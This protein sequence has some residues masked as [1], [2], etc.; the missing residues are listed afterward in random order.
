MNKYYREFKKFIKENYLYYTINLS[1]FE[2]NYNYFLEDDIYIDNNIISDADN[3]LKNKINLLGIKSIFDISWNKDFNTNYVWKNKYYKLIKSVSKY[4]KGDIKIPWELSRFHH[5]FTVS[6]AYL[7]TKD[8]KYSLFLINQINNWIDNNRY[9]F[10]VNWK[11]AMDVSIRSINLIYIINIIKKSE[12]VDKKFINKVN[13]LLYLQGRFIYNNLEKYNHTGNHY[14]T[15]LIGLLYLGVYFKDL[16]KYSNNWL[17]FAKNEMCKEVFIQFNK[18]G[19]NYETST[20]YHRLVLEMVLLGII[21]LD[22]NKISYDK[23]ILPILEKASEFIF[24]I[25]NDNGEAPLVGDNDNGRILILSNYLNENKRDL[26]HVL[27][28]AGEVFD[29]N[30][31]RVAGKRFE[32]SVKWIIRPKNIVKKNN[33]Y[34]KSKAYNDGGYY[35]LRNS[36][37]YS[38]IRCGEL[39]FR[40]YGTHSHNDQLSFTLDYMG[41]YIIIDPGTYV[42]TSNFTLR[43]KYR[44]TNMHNTVSIDNYEQNAIKPNKLFELKEQTFSKCIKFRDNEFIGEHSGYIRKSGIKHRREFKLYNNEFEIKDIFLGS[45]KNKKIYSYIILNT[46]VNIYK[47]ERYRLKFK[48]NN[49]FGEIDFYENEYEV[50]DEDISKEYGIKEKTKK[51]IIKYNKNINNYK[52][53]IWGN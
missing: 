5:L 18:D 24:D 32:N 20:S 19:T 9:L 15:D 42:Y 49:M 3:I 46:N 14:M 43:N 53:I 41:N 27:A 6:Q 45:I 17:D 16:K 36:K 44:A 29:R 11:C 39:A 10:G 8:E 7:I 28:L 37:F 1:D 25:I 38:L 48:F 33:Y 50:I 52:I 51:I 34:R 31:F 26:T 22:K 35:I 13:K 40:G 21:L 4:Q 2:S 47:F 12:L 30:D 23:N